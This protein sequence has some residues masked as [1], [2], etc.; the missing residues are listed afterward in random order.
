[1]DCLVMLRDPDTSQCWGAV[2]GGGPFGGNL[3]YTHDLPIFSYGYLVKSLWIQCHQVNIH[4]QANVAD[5]LPQQQGDIKLM[6]L[7]HYGYCNKN[8][9]MLNCCQ[10]FVKAIWISGICLGDGKEILQV[11]WK[12]E[13]IH[14]S[15]YKWPRVI[16]PSAK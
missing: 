13:Y 14:Q 8:L 1:M 2:A 9:G 6:W 10:M 7:C 12:G 4:I 5:I 3:G 16:K 11:E 15:P